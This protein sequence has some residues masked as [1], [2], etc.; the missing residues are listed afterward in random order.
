[1]PSRDQSVSLYPSLSL[2]LRSQPVHCLCVCKRSCL[3]TSCMYSRACVFYCASKHSEF[4]QTN[5][6]INHRD[7]LEERKERR[8]ES[9]RRRQE[10][11][12]IIPSLLF[13]SL[14]YL[15]NVFWVNIRQG[16]GGD[17]RHIVFAFTRRKLF[18]FFFSSLSPNPDR[19][20]HNHYLPPI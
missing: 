17:C 11:G 12:S 7:S 20:H 13:L 4:L 1:M 6:L 9:T 18:F 2:S 8:H 19:S 14:L 16:K 10:T 3:C 5:T 15:F